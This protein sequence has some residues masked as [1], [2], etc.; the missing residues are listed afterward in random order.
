MDES[1]CGS[2]SD[3]EDCVPRAPSH[4][5]LPLLPVPPDT[6][7]RCPSDNNS[8]RNDFGTPNGSDWGCYNR[9]WYGTSGHRGLS[10]S[11]RQTNGVVIG[12]LSRSRSYNQ[13]M[14]EP[15]GSSSASNFHRGGRSRHDDIDDVRDV[16][17]NIGGQSDN[18]W[19]QH[20]YK[21]PS[22]FD[23]MPHVQSTKLM[24]RENNVESVA[25]CP[26]FG[27]SPA[28]GEIVT[29]SN[30][31]TLGEL[32]TEGPV[33]FWK[34]PPVVYGPRLQQ[35]G[36]SKA[37]KKSKSKTALWHRYVE[38]DS[39]NEPGLRLFVKE[40][41]TAMVLK[42]QQ[43]VSEED[44]AFQSETETPDR[45]LGRQTFWDRHQHRRLTF[46]RPI[47]Y[48]RV[49]YDHSIFG[50]PLPEMTY[51]KG[52][53]KQGFFP[54]K[55]SSSWAYT[56]PHP[57]SE[58]H[59]ESEPLLEECRPKPSL[60]TQPLTSLS[61]SIVQAAVHTDQM[62]SHDTGHIIAGL[63]VPDAENVDLMS[64]DG[65]AHKQKSQCMEFLS[66]PDC[67]VE[68]EE[69]L[70]WDVDSEDDLAAVQTHDSLSPYAPSEHR[71]SSRELSSV[72]EDATINDTDAS[73]FAT[74]IHRESYQPNLEVWR[75]ET[76]VVSMKTP[77]CD[78]D[79]GGAE[80][81]LEDNEPNAAES[82]PVL[83]QFLTN[84]Y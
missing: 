67:H 69:Q 73:S 20:S 40:G 57:T 46:I 38:V 60:S 54:V 19:G 81:F 14:T 33:E 17:W 12:G 37:R 3:E 11:G 41:Q 76:E 30:L 25:Q 42:S 74:F 48:S 75:I 23:P 39:K 63:S 80:L 72:Q 62:S 45:E 8:N 78:T 66:L 53:S 68:E 35:T 52:T 44:A 43:K 61:S 21:I 70:D 9:W 58:D 59:V 26:A 47:N 77:D 13:G 32:V 27:G 51:V 65:T 64:V 56:Q 24:A 71:A 55:N 82:Y 36:K 2:L 5:L 84:I 1:D 4:T 10:D 22:P 49:Y 18:F 15:G 6:A 31:K 16:G 28:Q 29:S 7:Q 50:F 34:P 83:G 79:S